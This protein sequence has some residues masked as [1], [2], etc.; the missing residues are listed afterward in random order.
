MKTFDYEKAWQDLALPAFKQLPDQIHLLLDETTKQA[1]YLHQDKNLRVVWPENGKLRAAFESVDSD[2]LARAARVIYYFGHWRPCANVAGNAP[3]SGESWKFANYADQILRL[4]FNL[5]DRDN[6]AIVSLQIHEGT[7]RVCYSSPDSWIWHEVTPATDSGMKAAGGIA[8]SL[9]GE[10]AGKRKCEDRDNAAWLFM[11]KIK[12]IPAWADLD[13]SGYMVEET[14]LEIRRVARMPKP[15]K[16]KL[17]AELKADFDAKI[18]SQTTELNGFLW[19]VENDIPTSNA[20]YYKHTGRF[21]FGWR[22][23]LADE[24]REN[25]QKALAGFPFAYDLK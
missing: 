8:V 9:R 17:I 21:C 6:T 2:T 14:E 18:A 24:A 10:L 16:A 22:N 1:A 20:I 23:A 19:L 4:R 15:D 12:Q 3:A 11:E 7:I 5:P 25:M 13:S